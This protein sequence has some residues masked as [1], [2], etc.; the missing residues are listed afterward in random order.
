VGAQRSGRAHRR[1]RLRHRL[2]VVG[3]PEAFPV[4]TLKIDRSF[5]DGVAYLPEDQAIVGATV[6]FASALGM[7]VVAEG[8]ES[9]D[10][11]EVVRGLGCHLGQGYLWGKPV[12]ASTVERP[13]TLAA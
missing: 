6:A 3:V 7:T 12:P 5:V 13:Q 4:D 8:I 10:Q 2:L 9:E 11:A 1:R